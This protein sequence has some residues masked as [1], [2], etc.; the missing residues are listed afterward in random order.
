[1]T[2]RIP[3]S[4]AATGVGAGLLVLV[5]ALV[6][7]A[8]LLWPRGGM[9]PDK[10]ARQMATTPELAHL[11]AAGANRKA[12]Q[13]GAPGV[14]PGLP[15]GRTVRGGRQLYSSWEDMVILIA[16]PRTQKTT[17]FGVPAILAAP[18]ACLATSN[19]RD[20]YDVTAAVRAQV[21]QVWPF[22]PQG[23]ARVDQTWWWNPLTYIAP[24][25]ATTGRARRNRRGEVDASE[26]KATRLAAQ[27]V[28]S[29]RPD[30]GRTDVYF[31]GQAEHLIGLFLLAA[32]LDDKPITQVYSWLTRP[33]SED[34]ADILAAHGFALQ[35]E[36]AYALAHLPDK[37]RSGVYDT[38][39]SSLS[40][41]TSRD[42]QRWVT[43][44]H[45]DQFHPELFASSTDTLYALSRDGDA[46]AGPLVAALTMAVLDALEDHATE[47]PNGRLPVPFVGVLDEAAN[48]VRLR[49]LDGLYSHYGS[50]GILLVTILQSWH[51]G[52]Q[53]WGDHG[54]E[55][56][57]S[58]ANVRIYG[59]GVDDDR[60]LRR[61]SELIGAAERVLRSHSTSRG[62]RTITR[63]VQERVI[64]TPAELRELPPGRAVVF[65]SGT[66][67]VLVEPV[68][69]FRDPQLARQVAGAARHDDEDVS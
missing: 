4:G 64:L 55:K 59:G 15:I 42:V 20:V 7:A 65:A 63:N 53:V 45:G 9:R 51:Q 36:S 2:G 52:A 5:L 50:R 31:D 68:P 58:A 25:D 13:L 35:S 61:L 69:W 28:T 10:A 32:A 11:T 34:P 27:L 46:S 57:W 8:V 56:L 1:V 67:A 43:P 62:H 54:I 17:A 26:T 3:W 38:A 44:G 40:F 29:T 30:N 41:L 33:E 39:R 18:G 6:V 22:D 16:G 60:F 66:P 19:K 49:N 24:H 23:V 14:G 12:L 48:I 37:Q 47:S 21:G